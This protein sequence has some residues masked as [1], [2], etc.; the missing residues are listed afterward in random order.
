M[1]TEKCKCG[2]GKVTFECI[3]IDLFRHYP[4]ECEVIEE[5]E[6]G[7]I[8]YKCKK[9]DSEITKSDYYMMAR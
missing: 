6:K 5:K 3:G 7:R 9:C 1:E 2:V 4:K 8:I